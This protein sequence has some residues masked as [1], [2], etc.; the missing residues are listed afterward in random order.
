MFGNVT[1]L[2][3][4]FNVTVHC[5]WLGELINPFYLLT[6]TGSGRSVL[7]SRGSSLSLLPHQYSLVVAPLAIIFVLDREVFPVQLFLLE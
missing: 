1:D 2:I 3:C 4:R 5:L 7:V 6:C